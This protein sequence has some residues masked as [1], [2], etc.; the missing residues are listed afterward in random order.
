[1][2]SVNDHEIRIQRLEQGVSDALVYTKTLTITKGN[3]TDT[4]IR[5]PNTGTYTVKIFVPNGNKGQ[6]IET[7]EGTC[8]YYNA[9][10]NSSEISECLLKN[11]ESANP[12]F[13]T[14]GFKRYPRA[15]TANKQ[16]VISANTNLSNIPITFNFKQV[17]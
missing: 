1:M 9:E 3:W 13:I 4:G 15:E 5:L 10:T 14:L 11:S 17:I 6:Y 7:Y 16:F 8:T 12:N 2:A